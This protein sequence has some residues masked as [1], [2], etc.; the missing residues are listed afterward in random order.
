MLGL[1]VVCIYFS[2]LICGF[3]FLGWL[4]DLR[5]WVCNSDLF[6]FGIFTCCDF[7]MGWLGDWFD[8]GCLGLDLF[9]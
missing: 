1:V 6:L 8:G 2:V 7:L 9:V 3:V 5:V 4:L